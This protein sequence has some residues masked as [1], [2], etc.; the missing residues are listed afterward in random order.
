MLLCSPKLSLALGII[1][2]INKDANARTFHGSLR[3]LL[4]HG[5][6]ITSV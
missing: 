6:R 5:C 4:E 2:A 1:V 3:S